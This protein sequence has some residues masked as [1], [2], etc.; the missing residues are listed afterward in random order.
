[1]ARDGDK[2]F[3]EVGLTCKGWTMSG[4]NPPEEVG[5]GDQ[6]IG[7]GGILWAPKIDVVMVGIPP[8]HFGSMRR[9]RL[10]ENTVQF[11]GNFEELIKFV[12]VKLT[13][14]QV[15]SKTASVFDIRGIFAPI[16]GG[17]RLDIRKTAKVVTCWD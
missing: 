11:S 9:G 13:L 6:V 2:V 10:H 4:H 12:P 8:L 17:L 3:A 15:V 16:I 14:R 7:V 5:E 1:M